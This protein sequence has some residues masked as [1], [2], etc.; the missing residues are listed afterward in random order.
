MVGLLAV[1]FRVVAQSDQQESDEQLDDMCKQQDDVG[2]MARAYRVAGSDAERQ[3]FAQTLLSLW[4]RTN[5]TRN[6]ALNARL[7]RDAAL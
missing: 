6:V 4:H 7:V 1:N 2:T 5:Q 3:V